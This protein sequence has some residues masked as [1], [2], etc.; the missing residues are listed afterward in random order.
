MIIRYAF[1]AVHDASKRGTPQEAMVR[2]TNNA[3]PFE[4]VSQGFSGPYFQPTRLE[5]KELARDIHHALQEGNGPCRDEGGAEDARTRELII[6]KLA[7]VFGVNM[8]R[9]GGE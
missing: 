9:T 6:T 2:R 3:T 8:A 4:V 1:N 5:I 7:E